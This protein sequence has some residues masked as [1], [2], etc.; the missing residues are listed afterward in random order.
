[1]RG[2]F[3]LNTLFMKKYIRYILPVFFGL[4]ILLSIPTT[5]LAATSDS[6]SH[7][8]SST[9]IFLAILLLSAK[10]GGIV[11]KKEQPSVIG[12]LA[13]G[14]ILS[15]LAYLGIREIELIRGN[16][17]MAFFAE[18]GA[19]IL[20]FQIGLESDL[21][22]MTK[23]GFNAVIV[24]II[25]VVAPFVLGSF[26]LAP[27]LFP[28]IDFAARMFIGAALVATS[29]GITAYVYQDLKLTKSRACQTVLGAAVIDDILGLLILAIVSAIASGGVVTLSF[30]LSLTLRAFGFLALAV[31][32]GRLFAGK[33]SK[34]FS[35]ISTG[36]GMKVTIALTFA[37]SY[38]YFA[39][40]VGLAPIVGAFAAGLIL[41]AV[42]FKDFEHPKIVYDLKKLRGFD[43]DEKSK[44][45]KLIDRHSHAHVDDLISNIGLLLI[46]VFFVYTGLQINF[47][48]LLNPSLYL[49]ALIISAGAIIS[50]VIAGFAAK[51]EMNEKLLVGASMVPRGEVGLIFA[52]VGQSLGAISGDV[53]SVII[54][55]II[56]T[57]FIAPPM[58]KF[59]IGGEKGKKLETVKLASAN[60]LA[61]H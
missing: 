51:G 60:A 4:I 18:L 9:F 52:S 31:V 10:I 38:A 41:D 46:P 1:M 19:V 3:G 2:F 44:I 53:F 22:S 27:W 13:A 43:K 57:T 56:I 24:A 16:E 28:Q 58:I 30:V 47:A 14:I 12:E 49:Y 33:F 17:I 48:S 5:V 37:L 26:V 34:F 39:T 61:H 40:L 55:V 35:S 20:L 59:L 50:K 15:M 21:K 45:D 29:V 25:G 23:V 54:L 6:I 36:T 7:V 32:L 8:S 42:S 11:E